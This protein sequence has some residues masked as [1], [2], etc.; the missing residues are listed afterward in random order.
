MT[1]IATGIGRRALLAGAGAGSLALIGNRPA[2]GFALGPMAGTPAFIDALI[3]KM[4]IKEKAGQLS[5]MASAIG[6]GAATK[7]NPPGSGANAKQQLADAK[8]GKLTG[9]FNGEGSNWH[10]KLQQQ[11]MK[12]RLGIP[13]LFAADVIH[14]FRTIFPVPLGEAASF[15]PDLARRTAAAAAYEASAAGIDLTFAPMVD[16]ARDQRWGRGV[17]AAGEDVLVGT[18]FAAART[19]GFQGKSVSDDSSVAACAK[20]FA[21]Y[22]AG[23]AGMEYNSVDISE[24]TLRQTYLPPFQAAIGAGVASMMASFNEINGVPATANHW[25]L[26]DVLRGEWN[27]RGVVFSDYTADEELVAAGYAENS[28]DA[29][30]K[31]ILAGV[32]VSMESGLYLK[33]LPDLVA[34]GE[35]P[36]ARVDEAVRRVLT[37]KAAL[38]LFDDPYRRLGPNR[39]Q[40]RVLTAPSR[41]LA[42]EAARGSVVMLRNEGGLLPLRPDGTETIAVIGPF[43]FGQHDL[44]GPWNVYG[45]DNQAV[46]LS[47]GLKAAVRDPARLSF[48]KGSDV[49]KP[50]AGGI[51]AAVAAAQAADLVILAVGE[52]QE[53]SG[54]SQARTEIV[55]PKPQQQLV[56]AVA[57]AGKPMILLL[58]NGRALALEGGALQAQAILVTWFLG[59]ETGHALA[60]ILFGVVAPSGRLPVSFPVKSGQEPY[61][62]DHKPTGRPAPAG[63]RIPYKA[64][65]RETTNVARFPFGHGLTYGRIGYAGLDTGTGRLGVN[66]PLTVSARVSNSG[67]REAQE[68]VQLYVRQRAASIT[69]PV[70]RLIDWKR[71]TVAPGKT[72]T[73]SFTIAHDQLLYV[74][75]DLKPVVEPGPFDIWIAPDAETG[76]AGKFELV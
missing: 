4:T 2:F 18:R 20:H 56:D 13:M 25:L 67:T 44:I 46:D 31:A 47:T 36:M 70:R 7:L 10:R 75:G 74:G 61:H 59:T 57:E 68:V 12:S 39:E 38:G 19:A 23:E 54:E 24:R 11:A 29:A 40:T 76:L 16:I 5:I 33:Y 64:Q 27:F 66:A 65:Y 71:V 69:Q 22:G 52:S 43:A 48:V 3:A 73:V 1:G 6:G 42:R 35:V 63:P 60:D 30:K 9:I 17:E 14:G 62:Y 53:M 55:L 8:A 21:A 72:E 37:L 51:A 32:D 26:S 50:V 45:D 41:Q 15:D 49:E 58:K 34:A 28:R